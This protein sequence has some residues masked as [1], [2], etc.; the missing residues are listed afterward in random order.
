MMSIK[1]CPEEAS[2]NGKRLEKMTL[3]WAC[4]VVFVFTF[5]TTNAVTAQNTRTPDNSAAG[6]SEEIAKLL[7][8]LRDANLKTTHPEQVVQA[9]QRLGEMRAVEAIHDLVELL[10]FSRKFDWERDDMTVEIQP[11]TPATRFPAVSALF[12]IGRPA[13]SALVNVIE[14]NSLDS[15]RGQNAMYA[16]EGIFRDEPSEGVKYLE[17]AA[18][19]S[20]TAEST[21]HVSQAAARL[22]QLADRLTSNK[23]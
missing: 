4:A 20:A 9:V 6:R 1:S 17:R 11:I 2:V 12:Q 5:L 10:T 16:I 18:E 15:L 3:N 23:K 14:F 7:A 8:V 22:K 13:L 21:R 19:T